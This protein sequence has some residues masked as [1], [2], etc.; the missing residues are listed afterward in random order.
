[1]GTVIAYDCLARVRNCP[2]IS[3]LLTIGSPLGLD[4]IQDKLQPEWTR[5]NGFPSRT[6]GAWINVFD[7]LDPVAGFDPY[8]ANDFLRAGQR[9]IQDIHE[10]NSGQWRHDI[11]KY[12]RGR[13][14]REALRGVLQTSAPAAQ[15]RVPFSS[16][17]ERPAPRSPNREITMPS[18]KI[19]QLARFVRQIA[20]GD[21][22]ESLRR[23]PSASSY[24]AMESFAAPALGVTFEAQ[25]GVENWL[26]GRS[27]LRRSHEHRGDYSASR[28]AGG[29]CRRNSFDAGEPLGALR[30]RPHPPAA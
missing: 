16:R 13:K 21:A 9:V 12:L 10:P 5:H 3:A 6:V 17:A 20:P 15:A 24:G 7:H 28:A 22:V 30:R 8:L 26:W 23:P 2:A 27:R 11:Q 18:E 4:E 25:R 14:L 19:D 1:M 29:V